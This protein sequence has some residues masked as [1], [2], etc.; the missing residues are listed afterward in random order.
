[1][2]QLKLIEDGLHWTITHGGDQRASKIYRRHYTDYCQ[3]SKGGKFTGPGESTVLVLPNYQALF[4]W[5]RNTI[6]RRDCQVGIN[7]AV[8]RNESDILS[9]ELILEAEQWAVERWGQ[10][11][12]FTYIDANR[13]RSDNPGYCFK[14]AGWNLCGKSKVHKMLIMEKQLKL[15]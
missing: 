3:K 4:V 2:E 5:M 14:C 1:M 6:K 8:F 13:V 15:F 7:C 12:A 10:Q 11:R 9:S